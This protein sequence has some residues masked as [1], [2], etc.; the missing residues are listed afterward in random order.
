MRVALC[1]LGALDLAL[2]QGKEGRRARRR[3]RVAVSRHFFVSTLSTG[4]VCIMW[5]HNVT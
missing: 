1:Q 5:P 4:R 2:V 3:D